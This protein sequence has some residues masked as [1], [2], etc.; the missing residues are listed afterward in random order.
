[1]GGGRCLKIGLAAVR[2]ET[3]PTLALPHK[4]GGDYNL[5]CTRKL[6]LI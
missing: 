5:L 6:M 1:V 4:K 2:E 3:P